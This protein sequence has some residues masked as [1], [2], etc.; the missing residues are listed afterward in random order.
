MTDFWE[1]KD[2]E[3]TLTILGFRGKLEKSFLDDTRRE[4][5]MERVRKLP[6]LSL[7]LEILSSPPFILSLRGPVQNSGTIRLVVQVL[8]KYKWQNITKYKT[9]VPEHT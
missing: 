6:S 8:L 3:K 5:Y 4:V 2:E 7:I 1:E 9:I